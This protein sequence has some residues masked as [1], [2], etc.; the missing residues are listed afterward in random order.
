MQRFTPGIGDAFGPVEEEIKTAFLPELFKG[1]GD[2]APGRKITRL[3]VKQAVLALPKPTRTDPDNWQASC[4]ITGHLV[5]VLRGQVIFQTADHTSCL[6]DGRVAVRRKSVA[7]AMA[8]LE[9]NIAGAPEVVIRRLRRATKTGDWMTVQ[10]STVKGM[11]LVAQEWRDAAFLRYGLKPPDLPKYCD[12]CNARFLICYSLDCK[13]GGLVVARHNELCDGVAD[14]AGKAFTP[15][16][17]RNDPLI[18]QCCAVK[19]EKSKPS[20][21]SE[22]TD[23]DDTP[24]EVTE[25]NGDL[26]LRDLW[27]NGTDSVHDMRVV[28]TDAKSYWGKSPEKCLEEAEKS[29]KKMYLE[30]CLQQCRNFSP[31]VASVDGLLGVEAT[32]TLKRIASCLT[33]KWRQ[34]YS[35]TYRYVKSRIAITLV[36][37]THWCIR[38]VTGACTQDQ[39]AETVVGRRG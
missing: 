10:P 2:G 34:S 19:R 21:P 18:Y 38:G 3:S 30:R 33:S 26:L 1:V 5:S 28:N 25:Q 24:P 4:V 35:K 31:F 16:H 13:R 36:R 17:V 11:D 12:G 37:A 8:S 22:T 9:A 6:P 29:K 39:C 27:N 7:K 20:G 15:S 23:P 14:L 32:A